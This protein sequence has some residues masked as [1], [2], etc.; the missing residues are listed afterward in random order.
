MGAPQT[1]SIIQCNIYT[2]NIDFQSAITGR[3][4]ESQRLIGHIKDT[5]EEART[6][7]FV[8]KGGE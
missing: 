7:T 3:G 5:L 8:I 2:P 6:E 1:H 4:N